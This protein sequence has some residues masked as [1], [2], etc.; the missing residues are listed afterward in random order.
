VH[1]LVAGARVEGDIDAEGEP[2]S[3]YDVVVILVWYGTV[4]VIHDGIN[5]SISRLFKG[6]MFFN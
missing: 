1:E 6:I 2:G 4:S 3:I 5:K